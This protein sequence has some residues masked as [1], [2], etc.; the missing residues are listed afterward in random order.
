VA[1]YQPHWGTGTIY[2]RTDAASYANSKI[3]L[4][5]PGTHDAVDGVV[6]SWGIGVGWTG[7]GSNQ[8]IKTDITPA[9]VAYTYLFEQIADA[10]PSLNAI[11]FGAQ[12]DTGAKNIR[13]RQRAT[14]TESVNGFINS[15]NY[16]NDLLNHNYGISQ[17]R[18]FMDGGYVALIGAGLDVPSVP[19]YILA[20]NTSGTPNSYFNKSIA[21]FVIYPVVLTDN[22]IANIAWAMGKI[23]GRVP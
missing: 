3:N 10:P 5:T 19:I 12:S 20:L 11:V 8:Y 23:S 15:G 9:N 16:N 22:Q 17:K 6:P 1:A 2:A 14:S 18:A 7:N 21:S 4:N 13:V